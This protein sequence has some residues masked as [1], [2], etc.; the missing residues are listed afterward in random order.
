[1]KK[2]KREKKTDNFLIKNKQNSFQV[3]LDFAE[4]LN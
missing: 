2:K 1:M 3:N 4:W